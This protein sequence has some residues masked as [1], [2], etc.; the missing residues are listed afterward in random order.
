MFLISLVSALSPVNHIGVI[1]GLLGPWLV[2]L[3][4]WGF[5]PSQ[6]HKGYI[7]A[8]DHKSFSARQHSVQNNSLNLLMLSSQNKQK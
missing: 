1:S 7:R 2:E 4:S 8:D 3:V 6:P 5:E